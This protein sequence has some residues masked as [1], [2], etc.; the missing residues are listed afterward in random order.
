MGL[1]VVRCRPRKDTNNTCVWMRS[2]YV[3]K[4]AN[5]Y[6]F[7]SQLDWNDLCYPLISTWIF[8]LTM[9]KI[10]LWAPKLRGKQ[11]WAWFEFANHLAL[12]TCFVSY[13][14]WVHRRKYPNNTHLSYT[15][16]IQ[17][18]PLATKDPCWP[19]SKPTESTSNLIIQQRIGDGSGHRPT[20]SQCSKKVGAPLHALCRMHMCKD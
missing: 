11:L 18:R 19:C 3:L 2:N 12:F 16:P 1:S 8:T 6:R 10:F 5:H 13:K 17:P 15:Q 9:N 4:N 14:E 7:S 20:I